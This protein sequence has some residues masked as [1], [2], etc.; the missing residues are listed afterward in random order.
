MEILPGNFYFLSDNFF[1]KVQDPY[2]KKDY[3][4][5]KRPH[6]FSFQD[7]NTGLYWLVPCSSKVEKFEKLIQKKREQHKP[8][9]T[10]QII[11][12]LDKKTVLLFQDMFPV[13]E[14]YIESLYVKRGQIVRIGNPNQIR[15]LEKTAKKVCKILHRGV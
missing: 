15:E 4:S 2:L 5:T 1:K 9:D 6:Y 8:T 13:R 3:D 12:L 10:I 14:E 11:K 7:D